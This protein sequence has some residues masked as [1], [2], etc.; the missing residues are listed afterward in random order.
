MLDDYKRRQCV[1]AKL[2][3][4][5]FRLHRLRWTACQNCCEQPFQLKRTRQLREILGS[6]THTVVSSKLQVQ[7]RPQNVLMVPLR[8]TDGL[9]H[10]P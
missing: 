2:Q 3:R 1:N 5:S 6:R 9:L 7:M 8:E 4:R 10:W